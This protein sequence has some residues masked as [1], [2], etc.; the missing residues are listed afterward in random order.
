[1]VSCFIVLSFWDV[2][3]TLAKS[4]MTMQHL[5]RGPVE[6][7]ILPI[8]TY[9]GDTIMIDAPKL[10]TGTHIFEYFRD[11]QCPGCNTFSR[12]YLPVI[13]QFARD[14]RMQLI[15][16]QYPLE[17]LHQNAY[18]DAL[19]SLC[20]HEQGMYLEYAKK[21]YGLESKKNG[22]SISDGER[23]R[24][25]RWMGYV[26]MFQS[27]LKNA[28][29]AARIV[30]DMNRGDAYGLDGVPFLTLDGKKI[31]LDSFSNVSDLEALLNERLK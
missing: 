30:D 7:N 11:Y 20:A 22:K 31:R 8:T 28:V 1:M 25:F 13:E 12:D 9:S 3:M 24:I 27:C 29:Y 10:G 17:D 6:N 14:G 19:A 5:S 4:P 21:I 23:L 2:T 26:R 16:R 18:R 15:Y